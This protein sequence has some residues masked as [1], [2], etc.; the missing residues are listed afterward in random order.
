M[1]FY[2]KRQK[3]A[4]KQQTRHRLRYLG[5]SKSEKKYHWYFESH[6]TAER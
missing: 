4:G 1:E 6:T 5:V 3:T 2:V